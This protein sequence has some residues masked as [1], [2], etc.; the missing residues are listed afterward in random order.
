MFKEFIDG[1]KHKP[2]FNLLTR[3]ID[4]F[5]SKNNVFPKEEDIFKAFVLTSFDN[6]K[7]VVIAQDP[8]HNKGEAHGLAFSVNKGVKIPP[9]L[10]NIYKELAYEYDYQIPNH[11]N[12]ESW[13]KEGVLLLNTI[14][15]VTENKP[16]SHKDIGW[17]IFINNLFEFLQT[18]DHLVYLLLGNYAKK[19]KEK[20]TNKTSLILETSHPS[21]FSFTRGF[22]KSNIFKKTNEY[23]IKNKITPINWE[24]K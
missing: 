24:I 11:G 22:Y 5:R 9:S 20:V 13:A 15:T 17:E 6:L 10:R 14:L 21:P 16:L 19:Y 8:Y 3:R 12:L 1:E 4:E 2:Y 23:L 18:K 7:V